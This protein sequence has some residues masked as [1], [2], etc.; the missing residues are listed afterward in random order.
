MRSGGSWGDLSNRPSRSAEGRPDLFAHES[1]AFGGLSTGY[2]VS[3]SAIRIGLSG[4]TYR[5]WAGPFY[6]PDL[7]SQEWLAF[8]AERFDTVE[9]N[10]S[11]YS[12]LDPD[13]YRSWHQ[14]VPDDFVFSIKGSRYITH[15]KNLREV[16]T[17]L[18]NFLASGVFEL[19]RKL[20][21]ILWQLPP[22]RRPRQD[23]LEAFLELLP[24]TPTEAD[25]LVGRHDGRVSQPVGPSAVAGPLRHV[26]ELRHPDSFTPETAEL[27]RTSGHVIAFSHSTTWPY[28]E[29]LT[30]DFVYLR[31]H[32]PAELYSSPYG[33]EGLEWWASRI[34][35]WRRGEEP[36]DARRIATDAPPRPKIR[37]VFVYFDNDSGA[38]APRDASRLVEML[39]GRPAHG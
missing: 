21:P 10:R 14:T 17:P 19:R 16:E 32:G 9:V 31:L 3:V 8:V 39:S 25:H 37:D 34:E 1:P 6:P 28:T 36:S 30:S 18:A 13:V 26:I 22:H 27:I 7:P 24:S 20:G 35:A 12:L 5:D 15:L 23:R 38:H 29:E 4:W 33:E 2:S 11:F